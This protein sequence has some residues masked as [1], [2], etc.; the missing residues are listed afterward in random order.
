ALVAE[1]PPAAANLSGTAT[2]TTTP[3][4]AATTP[5]AATTYATDGR[6][7]V[8][9]GSFRQLSGARARVAALKAAGFADTRL[10]RFNR[11][12]FAVALAGQ[13]DRYS[14]A[15]RLAARIRDKG[16]EARVMRRR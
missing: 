5:V 3:T 12:T 14:E 13:E 10:E 1:A 11:G 8:I 6:Y 7:L 4:P 9:A 2:T 16:F 15:N